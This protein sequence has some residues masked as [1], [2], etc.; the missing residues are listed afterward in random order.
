[1]EITHSIPRGVRN[2]LLPFAVLVFLAPDAAA[3]PTPDVVVNVFSGV[4]QGAA[5]L[6]A[7]LGSVAL[8][9]WRFLRNP[10][11]SLH[12]HRFLLMA[13]LLLG[14]LGF[15]LLQHRQ[16]ETARQERLQRNLVRTS[17]ENG[18]Q[19]RDVS[20]KTLSRSDQETHPLGLSTD[21]IADR[22]ARGDVLIDVR[23][24]EEY[25]AGR[26]AGTR[27]VRYPDVMADPSI[28]GETEAILL[29]YSGNRSGELAE[30]LT[31]KGLPCRFMIGGYEKWNEEGRSLVGGFPGS[32]KAREIRPYANKDRLLESA[33]VE[34]E[35]AAGDVWFV[36]ARYPAEYAAQHLPNA[37]NIPLRKLLS[38]EIDQ[39]LSQV[40]PGVRL[41]GLCYDKRSSFYAKLLG[42]KLTARGHEW[43]GRYT[44]PHEFMPRPAEPS[45]LAALPS[46][47]ELGASALHG[48]DAV[49]GQLGIAIVLLVLALRG[50]ILP[51]TLVAERSNAAQKRARLELGERRREW[52][53]LR[54]SER[55]G[56]EKRILREHGVRPI[57]SPLASFAHAG[58]FIGLAGLLNRNPSLAG[59]GFVPGWIE[60]LSLADPWFVLP[61]LIGVFAYLLM[62]S[63]GKFDG[64]IKRFVAVLLGLLFVGLTL[65]LSA[66]VN[67]G[68]AVNLACGFAV[69]WIVRRRDRRFFAA[70][71]TPHRSGD[72]LVTLAEAHVV[73]GIGAKAERLGR[74]KALGLPVPDGFVLPAPWIAGAGRTVLLWNDAERQELERQLDRLAS[75]RM[76]VRSSGLDE[77]GTEHSFAGIFESCLDVNRD[78]FEQALQ[79][80]ISSFSSDRAK[81]YGGDDDGRACVLVQHMLEPE[82]AG[83]LF[84]RHPRHEAEMVVEYVQGCGEALVSGAAL[85]EIVTIGRRSLQRVEGA[86]RDV[87]FPLDELVAL[88]LQC[89]A[90]FGKPQDVEWAVEKG[91]V[92]ILQ[93]R[94][95][96]ADAH[97]KAH[98]ASHAVEAERARHIDR[99]AETNDVFVREGFSEL[100][101]RATP[102]SAS[103]LG[104][105]L[106]EGAAVHQARLKV[107]KRYDVRHASRA[108][109]TCFGRLFMS[110]RG[111]QGLFPVRRGLGFLR[112]LFANVRLFRMRQTIAEEW[113]AACEMIERDVRIEGS[114]NLAVLDRL[115]LAAVLQGRV[116]DYTERHYAKAEEI[117]LV[118][119]FQ[120]GFTR[121]RVQRAGLDESVLGLFHARSVTQEG[122]SLLREVALGERS[123][124]DY[125]AR[126]GHR[127]TTDYELALPRFVEDRAPVEAML[128]ALRGPTLIQG[129][130]GNAREKALSVVPSRRRAGLERELVRFG[131]LLALKE[132]ARH[133]VLRSLALVREAI[134]ELG[135]RTG[136]EAL[137][138]QLTLAEMHALGTCD[139][140]AVAT[141]RSLAERRRDE[142][143]AFDDL[144]ELDLHVELGVVELERVGRV[145]VDGGAGDQRGTCVCGSEAVEGV[146][147]V[148]RDPSE[149][150][151]FR[152]GEILVSVATDTSLAPLF[153]Q[154]RALITEVGGM[155]SHAAIVA[156]EFGLPTVV[157]VRGATHWIRT[158]DQ[159]RLHPNGRIEVLSNA[160]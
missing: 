104:A 59:R 82:Y 78:Q 119:A 152:Q 148:L 18:K 46:F 16:S 121:G 52:S 12:R 5:L 55:R 134:V 30:K 103:L 143:R 53:E 158:G 160:S 43:L 126:F 80:V 86:D 133:T 130:S 144:V 150:R 42:A 79:D 109:V 135:R 147:R 27:H 90:F 71:R 154:A 113:D 88:A 124:E 67:L 61:G 48:L 139:T 7:F 28:V 112:E 89:E 94:D 65:S 128:D 35:Y 95:I 62:A 159:V 60:D 26:I 45:W 107:G 69:A 132:T 115:E 81:S 102:A 92:Y 64:T 24:D 39:A 40:P 120:E 29:C 155:L 87:P 50:L 100:L 125:L 110:R 34:R 85:P 101:P 117:N 20:L 44:L 47:R 63:S 145:H 75:N 57:L 4:I 68:I 106:R 118:A 73:E 13:T 15:N 19:V 37:I 2:L 66:G 72:H 31:T 49:V 56:V 17:V 114:R 129:S 105:L 9:G 77:D 142:A 21:E 156:R 74:L 136:L 76:A 122:E 14:S 123:I 8:L 137:V 153:G 131:E 108:V 157:G 70:R 10:W 93:S 32:V 22:V 116:R 54:R 140:S 1:M 11:Q 38:S 111:M 3:I 99:L 138:F 149:L 33:D 25:D 83:V 98:D 97:G 151:L 84:T 96:T 141:W 6:S 127:A 51:L 91:R 146:A 23:E 58:L 36:D 41:V